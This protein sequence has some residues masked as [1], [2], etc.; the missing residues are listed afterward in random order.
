MCVQAWQSA[1]K[2]K[3]LRETAIEGITCK[4]RINPLVIPGRENKKGQRLENLVLRK[5]V[6][7]FTQSMDGT[8]RW[9]I[10]RKALVESWRIL[11][12]Q[13]ASILTDLE[14][15]PMHL[16]WEG[17]GRGF[18]GGTS[19][20][21]LTCQCRDVG[22]I[23][24]SGRFPVRGHGNPLQCSCLQDPMDRGAWWA[25][26]HRATKSQTRLKQFGTHVHSRAFLWSNIGI[27]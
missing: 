23:P 4:T 22:L 15:E 19:G 18:P 9:K 17:H 8:V 14:R 3:E 26:V 5:T 24:G 2:S 6:I 25:T 7:S 10:D 27:Y 20:K 1:F 16:S 11:T 13:G 21:E 12:T